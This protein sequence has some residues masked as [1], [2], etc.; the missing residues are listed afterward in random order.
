MKALKRV[1]LALVILLL[2]A[3]GAAAWFISTFDPNRYRGDIEAAVKDATGRTLSLKGDI[4]LS[5][6]PWLGLKLGATSLSNAPGFGAEPFASAKAIELHVA[7]LPLIFQRS[8]QLSTLGLDGL[9]LNLARNRQ[10]VTNWDDLTK[11]KQA[12]AAPA[13]GA[14]Q[15]AAAQGSGESPFRHITIEGVQIKDAVVHWHD[16]QTGTSL[17]VDPFNLQTGAIAEGVASPVQL[18]AHV[19][20]DKPRLD[21]KANLTTRLTVGLDNKRFQADHLKLGVTATGDAVPGGEVDASLDTNALVDLDGNVASL[22]PLELQVY[23]VD[24]KGSAAA[25][26]V[27]DKPVVKGRLDAG[28]F[29]PQVVLQALG[30]Q[31]PKMADSGSLTNGQFGFSF[32][33]SQQAVN[34]PDLKLQLDDSNVAGSVSVANFDRPNVNFNLAVDQLDA[35]NYLPPPE[36]KSAGKPAPAAAKPAAA[37]DDRIDLP[38]DLLRRLTLNGQ[39]TLGQLQIENMQLSKLKAVVSGANGLV[40]I[41]PLTAALYGGG[42][43]ANAALDVR[44]ATPVWR[45]GF[46]LQNVK[47]GDLLQDYAGDRYL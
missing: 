44:Q 14:A 30:I 2:L 1:V 10:G 7:L 38:T 45:G 43:N 18:S 36:K 24:I 37:A 13:K 20:L 47:L 26:G 40:A 3:I 19:K 29:N 39:L 35:D 27:P 9:T 12:P 11:Q 6:Y 34:V 25:T 15:P 41:K 21:I 31:L 46:N 16:A 22:K 4:Q 5:Y 32:T 23:G 42:L 33:A 8:L 17:V 28:T